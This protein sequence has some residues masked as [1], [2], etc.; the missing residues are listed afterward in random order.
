[1]LLQFDFNF[2][3]LLKTAQIQKYKFSYHNYGN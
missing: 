1:M 3:F 2:D